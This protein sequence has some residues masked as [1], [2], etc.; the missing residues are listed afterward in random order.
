MR[1]IRIRDGKGMKDRVTMLPDSV[2][3]PLQSHL[4]KARHWGQTTVSLFFRKS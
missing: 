4:D 1:E 3:G 2:C